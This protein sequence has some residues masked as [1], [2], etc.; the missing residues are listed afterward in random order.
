[1][2]ANH[3][4][5]MMISETS[6]SNLVFSKY[7]MSDQCLIRCRQSFLATQ[8]I[9]KLVELYRQR[10]STAK[11]THLVT[12]DE[13]RANDY[14]LS[15]QRYIRLADQEES[16]DPATLQIQ[17]RSI[18]AELNEIGKRIQDRLSSLGYSINEDRLP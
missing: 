17:H 16:V 11:N 9:N 10:T 3:S 6:G 4:D 5:W 1:M 2:G 18:M 15:I 7:S 13:I 8:D 14:N 12:L